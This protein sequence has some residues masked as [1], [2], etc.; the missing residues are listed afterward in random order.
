MRLAEARFNKINGK[1]LVNFSWNKPKLTAKKY[2]T[3]FF[4]RLA[5]I[6]DRRSAV[7]PKLQT[8]AVGEEDKKRLMETIERLV[9]NHDRRVKAIE[10]RE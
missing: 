4:N 1:T 5:V 10:V 8:K 2:V 6:E 3:V 7:V 9:P